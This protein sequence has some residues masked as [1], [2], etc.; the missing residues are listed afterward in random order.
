[1][2]CGINEWMMFHGRSTFQNVLN[3]EIITLHFVA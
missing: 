2:V 3:P 1:M